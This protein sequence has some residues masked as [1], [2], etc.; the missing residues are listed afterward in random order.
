M[1]NSQNAVEF[2]DLSFSYGEHRVLDGVSLAIPA[3]GFVAIL[4]HNGSGKTTLMKLALGLLP[5]QS[6]SIT[7]LG[8]GA[9]AFSSWEKIGYVQQYMEEFDFQFPATVME[10]VLMGRLSRKTGFLKGFSPQDRQAAEKALSLVGISHLSGR[11]IGALS[12]GQRQRVFL[13]KALASEAS[14]LFLDEPTTAMDYASQRSFYDVLRELNERLGITIIL[15]THDIGQILQ[16]VKRVAVLDRKVIF[17]GEPSK[18]D[19]TPICGITEK[20]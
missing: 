18:F 6:G 5:L 15:I 1:D 13:A 16:H 7:I 14:V 11:K 3:G 20:I 12:G 9:R 8:Q 17:E 19:K 4:G 10:I 2:R